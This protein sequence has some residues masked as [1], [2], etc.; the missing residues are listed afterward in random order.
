MWKQWVN[1]IIGLA[2]IATPFMGL[3]AASLSWTL[4][5]AG[6]V[7]AIL[8]VWSA[9]EEQSPEYHQRRLQHN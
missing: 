3:T 6:A 5:V 9:M 1:A 4:V 7:V 8:S 2:V